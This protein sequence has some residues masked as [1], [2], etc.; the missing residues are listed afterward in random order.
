[1]ALSAIFLCAGSAQAS[2]S[3]YPR[4]GSGF[5]T[6]AEGWSPG[7]TSCAPAALLCTPAASYDSE[8][9]NPPGSIAAKT[10]V[11]A[12]ALDLFKGTEVWDSPRFVVP[13][14]AVT[15][16]SVRLDRAFDPGGLV[17]VEP[18]ATY[19]VTVNDL[20][21]GTSSKPLSEELT[22]E[23][24]T[25]ATRSAPVSIVSGHEY[26]LSIESVTAQSAVAA[27][28]VTGTTAA[29]F[30]NVGVVVQTSSAGNGA[31]GGSGGGHGSAG[32]G[33]GEGGASLT[34]GRLLVLLKRG[35][36]TSPAKL[37]RKRLLVK[38]SC[39]TKIGHAC[40]IRAK[41]ML[42]RRRAATAARTVKIGKGRSRRIV[43]RVKP[44]ARHKLL[45][46]KRVLVRQRVRAGKT[47]TTYYQRRK[48]IRR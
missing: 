20:T 10:T 35:A 8:V 23:D 46:R 28:V 26:Q 27:S 2:N 19:T 17:N 45:R 16:A 30:D 36:T 22:K 24:S 6:S 12:N 31:G 33:A 1:V 11:T 39:P 47:R 25:F 38:V 14:G 15:G 44:K 32:N 43:L 4:G 37:R 5:A 40:H 41:A 9:G 42:T 13:V 18:K 29:R 34:S 48:L 21:A 7:A 3:V